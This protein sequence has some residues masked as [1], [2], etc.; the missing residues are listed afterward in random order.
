MS[1]NRHFI[2]DAGSPQATESIL[3]A[4]QLTHSVYYRLEV[5]ICNH[6]ESVTQFLTPIGKGG[7]FASSR[8]A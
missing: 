2:Y 5:V 1:C 3:Y 6:G 8:K 7:D 4:M